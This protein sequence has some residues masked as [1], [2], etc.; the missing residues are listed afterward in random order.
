MIEQEK[1]AIERIKIKQQK[2]VEKMLQAEFAKQQIQ[3][4]NAEKAEYEKVRTATR[5]QAAAER[6][7]VA[8][9]KAA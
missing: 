6:E 8:A 2:E 3:K 4:R 1:L 9:M 5:E 7:E